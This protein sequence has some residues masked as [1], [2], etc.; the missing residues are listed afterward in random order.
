MCLEIVV[1]A[2]INAGQPAPVTLELIAFAKSIRGDQAIPVRVFVLGKRIEDVVAGLAE[3]PGVAV[4]GFEGNALAAYHAEAWKHVLIPVLAEM[5]PRFVCVGHD[6][7]GA[8]FA[9][10]LAARLGAGCITGVE[11]ARVEKEGVIFQRSILKGKA[12][13]KVSSDA[14]TT[15]I[16]LVPGMFHPSDVPGEPV[17][18]AAAWKSSGRRNKESNESISDAGRG[19]IIPVGDI[20]LKSRLL[21]FLSAPEADA[22]LSGAEIIVSAGRGIVK[23]ENLSLIRDLAAIFSRSA[24]GGSRTVCDAGWLPPRLQI[25]QTGKTVSPRMYIACGISGALQHLAGMRGSQFI[26]AINHDPRAAIFQVADIAVVEDL[27]TF[28]PLLIDACR[29]L[30]KDKV[31]L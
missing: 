29:K 15:V 17:E 2:E 28:I 21:G 8:D 25:G 18:V 23:E 16:T 20:P 30:K 19:G 27:L 7:T 14:Q 5:R 1:I 9:P 22:D 24:V 4:A 31:P 26:V 6:S 10:G 12:I 11:N 3:I 13:M